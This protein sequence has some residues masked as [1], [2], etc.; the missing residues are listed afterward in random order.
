M[1][2]VIRVVG[3]AILCDNKVLCA[4]RGEGKS[5]AGY[6][7]FP[8]GKIEADESGPEALI[9]EI[10]EELLCDISVG[11]KICTTTQ[12][13]DF[14][15]IE[16]TTY[17]AFLEEG[18]PV[19]TE[20]QGLKWLDQNELL[21]LQWAPADQEAVELLAAMDLSSRAERA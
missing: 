17:L 9:R 12:E 10:K 1:A 13:Y 15:T 21:A 2:K 16:L 5:L 3:A 18:S 20:H 4:Q 11:Q 7:E 19:V 14:G 8:G 6:W